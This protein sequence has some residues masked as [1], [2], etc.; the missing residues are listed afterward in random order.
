MSRFRRLKL[1]IFKHFKLYVVLK[2]LRP[3]TFETLLPKLLCEKYNINLV[4]DLGANQGHFAEALLT[5]GYKG[6]IVSFG[7][8]PAVHQKLVVTAKKYTLWEL[9]APM[10]IGNAKKNIN[11]YKYNRSAFN[12][13]LKVSADFLAKNAYLKKVGSVVIPVDTLDNVANTFDV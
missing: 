3:L 6:K 12:F 4:Y 9:P 10:A 13:F 1:L 7:T 11:F 5:K 8:T 2:K